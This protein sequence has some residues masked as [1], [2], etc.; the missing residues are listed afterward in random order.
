MGAWV[1]WRITH[2]EVKWVQVLSHHRKL[3][4]FVQG[5]SSESGEGVM[6]DHLSLRYD[7]LARFSSYAPACDSSSSLVSSTALDGRPSPPAGARLPTSD[8]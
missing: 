2:D 8:L 7:N 4:E 6:L 5:T 1:P 3:L